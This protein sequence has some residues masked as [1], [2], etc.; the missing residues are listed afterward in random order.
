MKQALPG[1][2]VAVV[3]LGMIAESSMRYAALAVRFLVETV[4]M[5]KAQAACATGFD[6]VTFDRIA[7]GEAPVPRESSAHIDR[8]IATE[9]LLHSSY[10]PASAGAWFNHPNPGLGGVSPTHLL[11]RNGPSALGD[12]LRAAAAR[13]GV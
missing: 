10:T 13:V 6:T 2:N 7:K 12:V 5:T 4:G 8:L 11:V 3:A 9:S 1:P